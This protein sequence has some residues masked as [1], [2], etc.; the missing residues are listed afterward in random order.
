MNRAVVI[1]HTHQHAEGAGKVFRMAPELL[2]QVALVAIHVHH[3]EAEKEDVV[4]LHIEHTMNR[5]AGLD[6]RL[7]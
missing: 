3:L 2:V 4:G 7:Y 5:E 1:G 6:F